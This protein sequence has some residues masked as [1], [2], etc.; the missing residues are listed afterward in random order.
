MDT[1]EGMRAIPTS[2]VQYIYDNNGS[3]IPNKMDSDLVSSD[4]IAIGVTM[5]DGTLQNPIGDY[6]TYYI[7]DSY[8][9]AIN[10]CK[11]QPDHVWDDRTDAQNT[12]C[13]NNI[14]AA[15]KKACAYKGFELPSYQDLA[16]VYCRTKGTSAGQNFVD[17]GT[18]SCDTTNLDQAL[19][20][21]GV[22][23][24]SLTGYFWSSSPYGSYNACIVDFTYGHATYGSVSTYYPV[25]CLGK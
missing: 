9:A 16:K 4:K 21:K 15:A 25:L 1:G 13:S 24:T 23:K 20:I 12:R 2:C 6:K 7:F 3:N 22:E 17:G 14:W 11:G 19:A 10:T 8:P 18:L 5:P